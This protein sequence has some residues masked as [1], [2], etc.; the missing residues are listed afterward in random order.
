MPWWPWLL[1]AFATT[2]VVWAGFVLWLVA[3]GRREDARALTTFI[4]D[5]IC[6]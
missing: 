3:A 6:S 1:I 4:P 2:V 5:C